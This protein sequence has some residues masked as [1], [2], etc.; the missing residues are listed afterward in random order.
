MQWETFTD[1]DFLYFG[2]SI[3]LYFAT[4]LRPLP[5]VT[6][7]FPVLLVSVYAAFAIAP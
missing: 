1:L 5:L 3:C 2:G 7:S 4:S 6:T